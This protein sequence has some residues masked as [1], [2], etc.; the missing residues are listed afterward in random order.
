MYATFPHSAAIA[1]FSPLAGIKFVESLDF[2][3]LV[4]AEFCF[5]PLAGIKFVERKRSLLS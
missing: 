3:R 4:R 1:S 2:P 5:S